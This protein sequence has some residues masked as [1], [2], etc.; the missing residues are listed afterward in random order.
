MLHPL[1]DALGFTWLRGQ[2]MEVEGFRTKPGVRPDSFLPSPYYHLIS[3]NLDHLRRRIDPSVPSEFPV[4]DDLRLMGVTD[5]MAF[6]HPFKVDTWQGMMGSWSTDSAR[7]ASATD[8]IAA[9]L[10]I[11]NHLAI[12]AKMAVLSQLAGNMLTTYLGGDAGRRVLSGQIKRGDGETIRAALVMADMRKSTVLAE[13]A[14][15][16]GLYRYAEP[17]LR[18]HRRAFQSQ[19]RADPEFP[20]RRLPCRLS[21]RT[22]P[23]AVRDRLPGRS[24][25]SAQGHTAHDGAQS[26]QRS[27]RGLARHRFWHRPACRQC[28]VRQCRA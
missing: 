6:I 8:M 23:R 21:L 15:R 5:Y 26:A 25:G 10:R 17:V 14:G 22:A 11:Q 3:N 24:C 4:F 2:G 16:A 19:R 28:D 1:Y 20:R 12:A 9:L 7:Q 27:S 13:K 18:C